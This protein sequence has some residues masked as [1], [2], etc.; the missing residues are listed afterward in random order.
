ML[1]HEQVGE[2]AVHLVERF[3][4]LVH[5]RGGGRTADEVHQHLSVGIGVEDCPFVLQFAAQAHAIG[6]VAVVAECDVAIMEAEQ[7]RLDVVHR[8]GA[9]CR[10]THVADGLVSF[11]PFDFVLVGEHL[12]EQAEPAMPDEMTVIVRDDAGAFLA[13]VLQR[14]QTK[15]GE[16]GGIRVAPDT[17][18]TALFVDVFEFS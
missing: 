12:G 14:V 13:A 15:I 10:V 8:S 3:L 7:E 11:E 5:E 4:E 1:G 6:E 16:T 9:G 2:T 17:E 18:N